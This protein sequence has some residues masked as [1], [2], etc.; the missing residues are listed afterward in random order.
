MTL[1]F[2]SEYQ[3]GDIV[4]CQ[5]CAK[6]VRVKYYDRDTVV[7]VSTQEQQTLA[8]RCQYCGYVLCD[9]C[10]HPADSLFP[11]CPSC[12]REWGPY[13]FTHDVIS[14]SLL[15]GSSED[16]P[17]VAQS[18]SYDQPPI[19]EP[20]PAPVESLGVGDADLYGEFRDWDRNKKFKKILMFLA[21]CLLVGVL[22]FLAIGPGKPWV[23][24]GLDL[25]T[26][27]P[28]HSPTTVG[29]IK[30][31][32]TPTGNAPSKTA[33]PTLKA[34]DTPTV[35]SSTLVASTVVKPM[36][37]A[38]A[39]PTFTQTKTATAS[40]TITDTLVPTPTEPNLAPGDCVSALSITLA[41]VGKKLCVTGT[42]VYT[43]QN[44]PAFQIY[45]ANEDGYFRI[46][47]YDRVPKDIKAGVCIKVT[48]EIKKLTELPVMALGYFDVIEICSP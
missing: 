42:V 28:T 27:R 37:T 47:V 39:R 26:T 34:S 38:T 31:T 46:V 1:P 41:D 5:R 48:G 24:K 45:F 7:V 13:Y 15:K 35:P 32:L 17:P 10:A 29:I 43:M 23:R 8:L 14:P 33:V 11:I 40:P 36:N 12:Q 16:I 9:S 4:Q 2:S 44:G 25:L 3:D 21:G 6:N 30:E 22:V 19:V 18:Q 20:P